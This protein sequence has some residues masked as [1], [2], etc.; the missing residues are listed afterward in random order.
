MK[1]KKTTI[2]VIKNIL[3]FIF[4]VLF[5]LLPLWFVIVNSFKPLAEA[6][7]LSLRLPEDW[8]ILEN[9]SIV[10]FEG[11]IARGFLNTLI[12]SILAQFVIVMLASLASWVFARARSKV[13]QLFYYIAISG[14]LIPPA[15]ITTIKV[16]KFLRIYG[17]LLGLTIFYTGAIMSFAIFFMTGFIKTIPVELEEAARIDGATNIG[18]FF[19][20]IFPLLT[21]VISTTVVILTLFTW[22]DFIFP[23][24]FV[25]SPDN[26][27]MTLGL[28][29]FIAGTY[30]DTNW[31]LVFADIIVISLP[32]LIIFFVLQKRIVRGL[33]GGA[34]K[35]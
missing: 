33:T 30:M 23:F 24:Y 14:I 5:I 1:K 10:F 32:L 18:L 16:L 11:N 7:E 3:V 6:K 31:Q 27:T 13:V 22:N 35:G 9:Y 29:N 25:R 19:R 12:I 15:V 17:N 2:V 20:I 34:V 28:Y 8:K 21:P 4:A 26:Y